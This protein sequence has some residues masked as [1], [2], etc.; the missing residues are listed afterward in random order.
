LYGR[1]GREDVVKN[2]SWEDSTEAIE[3][4]LLETTKSIAKQ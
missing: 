1:N 4:Y 3:N 2:W